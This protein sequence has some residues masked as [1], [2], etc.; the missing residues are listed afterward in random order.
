MQYCIPTLGNI[1]ALGK[2]GFFFLEKQRKHANERYVMVGLPILTRK[3][4]FLDS[5]SWNLEA[6]KSN[7]TTKDYLVLQSHKKSIP[8]PHSF[9]DGLINM[10][11]DS[12]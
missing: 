5:F 10:L 8:F 4:R 12:W 1:F 6:K 2:G 3:D 11:N 9:V 7:H